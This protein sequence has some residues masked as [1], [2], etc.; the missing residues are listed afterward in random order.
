MAIFDPSLP[1]DLPLLPPDIN[2][3][4]PNLL[5]LVARART[6]L[7][8]LKGFSSTVPNPMLLLSPAI[9]RES[10]ASSKIENINTTIVD[11]FKQSLFPEY[12]RNESDKEVLRYRNAVLKGYSLL[13]DLPISN[14][15]IVLILRELL[16]G[17][18]TEIRGVQNHIR[19]TLTNEIIYT[20]PP[21]NL[22][23]SLISN[24]EIFLNDIDDDIDPLIKCAVSHY[25]FEAIHPFEDGNGRTGR[26]LM[27]LYLVQAKI[28]SL[29]ILYIS[30]YINKNR[31]Q[32]YT[33]LSKVT[34]DQDW[35]PFIEF[36]LNALYFQA[37]STKETLVNII[38]LYQKYRFEIE[39]KANKA[40]K[41]GIVDAMF[42]SPF[43]T[44]T[45]CAAKIKTHYTTATRYLNELRGLGYLG[46]LEL[47]KFHYYV[48]TSL[49]EILED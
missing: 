33:L 39:A 14:R 43:L 10:I 34:K 16:P 4:D 12:E 6:E 48:N 23:P 42:S 20:P 13:K 26:I 2:F 38:N 31:S 7:G 22:I 25:Q 35:V 36:I 5:K 15:I 40:F 3:S 41:T 37:K 17:R 18:N 21:V 8:E 29:P 27:V 11:V 19:N 1:F 32:Y 9:I 44:P 47:G 49:I 45:S 24:L 30:G 28:L 46:Y